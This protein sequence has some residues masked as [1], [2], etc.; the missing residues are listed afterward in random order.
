[1]RRS[2]RSGVRP[3]S[4]EEIAGLAGWLYTD[5]ML[6]LVVV[7]L[8]ASLIT[9]QP[10]NP[11]EPV[12]VD[13]TE[14]GSSVST[15]TTTTLPPVTLCRSLYS[16]PGAEEREDGLWVEMP[17]RSPVTEAT[18]DEFLRL[19]QEQIDEEATNG[20]QSALAGR[21]A[22]DTHIG[23]VLASGGARSNEDVGRAVEEARAFVEGLQRL[24]PEI[25]SESDS[26]S[27]AI[28]RPNGTSSIEV[29]FVGMDIFPYVESP[30]SELP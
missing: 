8:G 16:S 9:Q 1:M 24:L 25:F 17:T 13:E 28:I 11:P 4:D 30:C 7:F 3:G 22:S 12:P 2:I 27:A 18:R 29:G 20:P 26:Y 15:S 6:G 21:S 10:W 5:L 23:L 19:Y 14:E